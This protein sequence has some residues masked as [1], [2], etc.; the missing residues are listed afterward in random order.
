MAGGI[1]RAKNVENLIHK[2]EGLQTRNKSYALD[3]ANEERH[4]EHASD[5][6]VAQSLQVLLRL[7]KAFPSKSFKQLDEADLKRFFSGLKPVGNAEERINELSQHSKWI[8]MCKLKKF[9]KWLHRWEEGEKEPDVCRWIKNK[10]YRAEAPLLMPNDILTEEEILALVGAVDNV[11]DKALLFGL[12]ETGC[13]VDSEFLDMRLDALEMK[14]KYAEYTFKNGNGNGLKTRDSQRTVYFVNSFPYLRAWIEHHPYKNVRGAYL[15]VCLRPRSSDNR[16]L[17]S[18][19]YL[20]LKKLTKR[21]GLTK[22]IYP[23]LF[24]H[25]RATDLMRKGCPVGQLNRLMGWSDKASQWKRYVHLAQPDVK[26][27]LMEIDGHKDLIDESYAAK[28]K[29]LKTIVCWKCG[30]EYGAGTKIC[31]CGQPL[32]LETAQKQE[33]E[34]EKRLIAATEKRVIGAT[35][36]KMV[37]W[38]DKLFAERNPVRETER[39]FLQGKQDQHAKSI[40]DQVK[41]MEQL[42]KRFEQL[43]A[44]NGGKV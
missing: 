3:F 23:H 13:R 36:K 29:L 7:C 27:T 26:N 8:Y 12:F 16:L 41:K 25:S 38:F 44:A 17:S 21:V 9:F 5:S 15:W 33:K 1:Y 2:I 43:A 28:R 39:Q 20:L 32:D 42:V 35:E 34:K 19:V 40:Q 22:K 6:S 10:K 4:L 31:E 18:G 11:R 30:K 24:R 37:A 14:E